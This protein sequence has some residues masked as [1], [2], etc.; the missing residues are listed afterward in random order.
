MWRSLC[1]LL[2]RGQVTL[3]EVTIGL[4]VD[5]IVNMLVAARYGDAGFQRGVLLV[6]LDLLA[7]LRAE[8]GKPRAVGG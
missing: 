7:D 8:L 3:V 6:R 1:P 2:L 5:R 4:V